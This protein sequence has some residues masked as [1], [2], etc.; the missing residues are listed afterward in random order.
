MKKKNLLIVCIILLLLL[1]IGCYF[2]LSRKKESGV[3]NQ[4]FI[5]NNE[6]RE[7]YEWTKPSLE[8]GVICL[9]WFYQNPYSN[10]SFYDRISIVLVGYGNAHKNELNENVLKELTN[11][12]RNSVLSTYQYYISG[13]VI[14]DKMK[15]FFNEKVE[16]FD[17]GKQ[18]HTW[19]YH[20]KSDLF[21]LKEMEKV[22]YNFETKQEVFSY[23]E[24]NDTITL[25]V[26]KAEYDENSKK[27]YRYIFNQ[28]TFVLEQDPK[29]FEFTKE[30]INQFPQLEYIFKKNKKGHYYLSDIQNLNFKDDFENCNA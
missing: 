3:N 4:E 27:I 23:E 6:V 18:Y 20:E 7:I 15:E 24:K 11:E 17:D 25:K 22:P 10:H 12:E 9:G 29:T 8:S 5:K 14:R 30:N 26:V 16:Y 21:L 28:E 13:K 2:F 19:Y 1:G